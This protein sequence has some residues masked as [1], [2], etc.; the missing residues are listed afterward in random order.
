MDLQ[1][2]LPS[3][4]FL[5]LRGWF[6]AVLLQDVG[7]GSA[8]NLVAQVGQCALNPRVTPLTIFPGHSQGQLSDLGP[9][10]RTEWTAPLVAVVLADDQPAMPREHRVR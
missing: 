2:F 9:H 10:G 8:P 5:P 4:P 6:N 3:R 7:D 1:E